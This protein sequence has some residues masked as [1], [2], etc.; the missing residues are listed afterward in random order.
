MR[1]KLCALVAGLALLAGCT[2]QD[3]TPTPKGDV[4]RSVSLW[5]GDLIVA[6]PSG[7]CIESDLTN[8]ETGFVVLAGCDVLTRGGSV[9][10]VKN[11]VLIVSVSDD[12]F[13][14]AI[15]IESVRDTVGET[16]VVDTMSSEGVSLV[17]LG[18]GG[19]TMLSNGDPKYWRGAAKVNGYLVVM[20][21]V[22]RKDGAAAN[23]DGA[24][25]LVNL[26][27]RMV[28]HSPD[29]PVPMVPPLRPDGLAGHKNA[30]SSSKVPPLRPV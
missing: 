21:A 12:R 23:R 27:H 3:F 10:P 6:G 7:Y 2:M 8:V 26:V 16:P 4:T 29:R 15:S 25:L 18:S 5:Q 13:R 11:A 22:S 1:L 9:G 20:T 19:E 17:Q 28:L 30:P 14:D 24:R